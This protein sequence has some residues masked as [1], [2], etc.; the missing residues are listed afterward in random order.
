[1]HVEWDDYHVPKDL[2]PY[3]VERWKLEFED[4]E[5]GRKWFRDQL[6]YD[7]KVEPDGSFSIPEVLP[8]K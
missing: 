5:A 2:T 4:T 3:A 7:F 8:G 1:M 6:A